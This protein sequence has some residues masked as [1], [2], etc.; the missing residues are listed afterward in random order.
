MLKIKKVTLEELAQE[1]KIGQITFDYLL[2][3]VSSDDIFQKGIESAIEFLKSRDIE[4]VDEDVVHVKDNR[5][6]QSL[7]LLN[8]EEELKL[9]KSIALHR[10][11]AHQAALWDHAEKILEEYVPNDTK[12][13]CILDTAKK[14]FKRY[15]KEKKKKWSSGK[16]DRRHHLVKLLEEL[17]IPYKS[18]SKSGR[19]LVRHNKYKTAHDKMAMSNIRLAISLAKKSRYKGLDFED[20]VQEGYIGLLKA[21]DR[22]DYTRENRFSTYA[23]WWIRQSIGTALKKHKKTMRVPQCAY[24]EIYKIDTARKDYFKK[25]GSWPSHEELSEI[26]GFTVDRVKNLYFAN[27]QQVSLNN[28]FKEQTIQDLIANDK[29]SQPV[30]RVIEA[31]NKIGL[32]EMLNKLSSREATIIMMRYNIPPY[33]G[34]I[35]TLEDVGKHFNV[36]RERI[37]QIETGAIRKLQKIAQV[38]YSGNLNKTILGSEHLYA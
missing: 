32:N 5:Y 8:R 11:F 14:V 15:K 17:D 16:L 23:C 13:E 20:L 37:R 6:C 24:E 4:V 35:Y 18:L 2:K 28:K 29:V 30:D 1:C 38:K 26:T 25:N 3:K 36:T 31:N 33:Q 19:T 9:A 21:V 10:K 22:F 34:R 7:P 27:K 12:E